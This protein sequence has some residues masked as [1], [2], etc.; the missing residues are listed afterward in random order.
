MKQNTED[1]FYGKEPTWKHWTPDDFKDIEK[2]AWSIAMSA[3]WY[4]IRY[5]ERDYRNA[6]LEYAEKNKI[7]DWQYMKK[8]GTDV[9]AFRSI[10]GKCKASTKGCIL[11]PMFQKNVDDTILQLIEMG[12]KVSLSEPQE[13]TIS[14]RDRVKAQSCVLASELEEQIDDYLQYI[15]GNKSNY[16]KF[17]MEEWLRSAEPSGMHCHF[18]L[19]SFEPRVQELN[20]ALLGENK[21]LR[22][23]YSYITKAQLRKL[24]DFHKMLCD[25]LRLHIGIINSNRKP[26]K[27][28][29]KKPDQVVKK[30]KY[31]IKDTKTGAESILPESIVGSSTLIVFNTKTEKGAIYYAD[32]SG[33]GITVKGTTLIGFDKTTSKEKKIKKAAEFIKCMKKDGIRAI[34]NHWKSINTKEAEPNGRIN[35][36]TLLL[37]SIK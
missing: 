21:E 9:F 3:N 19:E 35:A 23:A 31:L 26:R 16:K 2:V 25:Y 6:V 32:T 28:K 18:M 29:K 17:E 34:N 11:P 7:Q 10:G 36:N 13:E 24:Y 5:T 1:I 8:L 12:K 14:V 33:S 22:E 37:R 27:K 4:N 20:M 30:L 15:I